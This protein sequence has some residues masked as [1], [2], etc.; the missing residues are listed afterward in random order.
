VAAVMPLFAAGSEL[1]T[2]DSLSV[3][4]WTLAALIF[5]RVLHTNRTIDWAWLGL[6]IG[7]G[8]LGKFT[9]GV[10][11]MCIGLFLLWSREHRPLLFNWK[12]WVGVTAFLA[13]ISPVIWWNIQTGW[14][15]VIALHSRS[16]VTDRFGIHP[17]ELLR[18]VGEQC[19]VISPLLFA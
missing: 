2:I 12:P 19:G 8:F 1:M 3:L 11:F 7:A 17:A 14:V 5:W 4:F 6:A 18:F 13:T 16:G 10:Q 15:H 9:N